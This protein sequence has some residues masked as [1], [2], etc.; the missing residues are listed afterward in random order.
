MPPE[1]S[2]A[3]RIRRYPLF[4]LSD[5]SWSSHN[6]QR[7][8]LGVTEEDWVDMLHN[9]GAHVEEVPFVLNGYESAFRTVVL[10]DLKRLG[11]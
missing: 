4:P 2:D 1:H 8:G 7:R 3:V 10:C 5:R 6:L 11:Q 9:V